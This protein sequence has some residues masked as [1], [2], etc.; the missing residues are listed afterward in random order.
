VTTEAG[1]GRMEGDGF[2][3]AHSQAQEAYGELG[4]EW[5]EQAAAE[6][7][8]PTPPLPFVI[9]DMGAAG[10]GNSLEP[11]RRALAARPVQ[12]PAL[13]V[14]TDIPG[15][16]FNAL[17]H[18]LA[19][20]PHS[21]LGAPDV[22][23][24]A[25]AKSFFGPLFPPGFLSLGWSSIAVH[26]LSQVPMP[27]ADHIYCSFAGGEEREALRAQSARDWG[28]F[29]SCRS[30][31]LRPDGRLVVIG[32]AALDDGSSG[33]EGLMEIGDEAL[34]ALVEEGSLD[35][36]DYARMTIPTWNRSTAEFLAPFES[37][38]LDDELRLR[39]HA[40]RSLPDPY[41]PAY[42]ADGNL[43]R[44]VESVA[45]FFRAAFEDSLWAALGAGSDVE[46]FEAR[47][48]KLLRDG[49]AAAPERAACEWHVVLLDIARR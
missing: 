42:R 40:A 5:L 32:G 28:A 44:Y 34:R 18:L 16:D 37:G 46:Q 39:R 38:A 41:L 1:T 30:R 9:A 11:M 33:A 45:S 2:Y 22:F 3:T 26:W 24:A 21:Y 36:A 20:S 15:N 43:D 25:E 29:L 4:F 13:V 31:E 23:A 47:F 10:G 35:A 14:H 17:F 49:I 12:G 27:I 6:V 19:E 7:G 48:A 8:A